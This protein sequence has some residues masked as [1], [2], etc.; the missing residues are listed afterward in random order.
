MKKE[1]YTGIFSYAVGGLIKVANTLSLAFCAMRACGVI[2]WSWQQ[3][4]I[5][6]FIVWGLW[7][8]A[9]VLDGFIGVEVVYE[10]EGDE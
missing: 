1:N 10:E 6:C 8:A 4:M 7:V 5:P 9:Y 2:Q 3:I